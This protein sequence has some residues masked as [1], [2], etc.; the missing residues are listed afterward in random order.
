MLY[1]AF[2]FYVSIKINKKKTKNL[3]NSHG[4][5]CC[6]DFGD[7]GFEGEWRTVFG[8]DEDQWVLD[9]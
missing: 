4:L 2:A 1:H 3:R 9:T 6:C 5:T 7:L 8:F